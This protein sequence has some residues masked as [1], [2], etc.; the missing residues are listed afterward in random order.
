MKNLK[1]FSKLSIIIAIFALGF[2]VTSCGKDGATGPEG[3]QGNANVY[4]NTYVVSSW[5]TNSTN[6]YIDLY[7][8]DLTSDVQGSGAVQVFL[9]L[10]N[11]V[12]WNALPMTYVGSPYYVM[13]YSTEIKNVFIDWIYSGTGFGSDPN[14]VYGTNCLFKVVLIPPAYK[15]P[16][17]NMRNYAEVKA[18]YHL[19]D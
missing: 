1:T 15:K 18:A 16:N 10:N 9:S 5:S 3:P 19:K 2:L 13:T 7:D 14:T 11:G 4:A 6:Y 8:A 17:V 12:D